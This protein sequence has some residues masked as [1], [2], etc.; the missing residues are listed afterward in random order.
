VPEVR[1]TDGRLHVQGRREK[2]V[3][4]PKKTT[5]PD[6]PINR[7]VDCSACGGKRN[8]VEYATEKA[9]CGNQSY[10]GRAHLHRRCSSCGMRSC[11]PLLSDA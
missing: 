3:T 2:E 5:R 11:E 9:E 8:V 4:V 1:Q 7:D 6:T 10:E